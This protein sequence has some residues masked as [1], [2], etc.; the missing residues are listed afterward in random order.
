M[1]VKRA[2]LLTACLM[3]A[4]SASPTVRGGSIDLS[5]YKGKVVLLNFWATTCGGC[6]VEIP[7]FMEFARRYKHDGLAV[8]G[9]SLDDDGWKSV[10]PWIKARKLNYPVVI[11]NDALAKEY[12]AEELPKTFLI[13]RTGRVAASHTGIVNKEE[14]EERIRKLIQ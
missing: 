12:D 3:A 5:A 4:A 10:K 9:V 6:K 8:I 7:W 11:G 1:I 13:D 14:W 2:A